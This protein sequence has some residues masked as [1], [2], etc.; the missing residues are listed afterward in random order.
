[1]IDTAR[2][3]ALAA[4]ARADTTDGLTAREQLAQ[5]VE[6]L[7]DG[8]DKACARGDHWKRVAVE[9]EQDRDR[10]ADLDLRARSLRIVARSLEPLIDPAVHCPGR[11]RAYLAARG[12]VL[13]E[14]HPEASHWRH[15]TKI[16]RGWEAQH[17]LVLMLDSTRFSDYA[18]RMA[19]TAVDMAD[20]EGVGELQVLADIAASE[21]RGAD[22]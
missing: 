11:L 21:P 7:C 10:L 12:W 8:L 16:R 17:S 15:D 18:Q 14:Q 6:E 1:M 22:V 4:A 13:H 20:F 19:E 2:A 9:M 3:R 5:V